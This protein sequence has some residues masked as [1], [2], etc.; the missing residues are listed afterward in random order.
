[1]VLVELDPPLRLPPL[2]LGEALQARDEAHLAR[3]RARVR[4]RARARVRVRVRIRVRVRVI[5]IAC[6]AWVM[7]KSSSPAE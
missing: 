1:M 7:A 2:R 4:A 3:V 5:P 6:P